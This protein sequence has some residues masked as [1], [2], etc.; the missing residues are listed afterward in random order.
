MQV[1]ETS[2]PAIGA[3]AYWTILVLL[4]ALGA[5]LRLWHLGSQIPFDDEWHAIDYVLDH[6]LWS[7]LGRYTRLGANSVPQNVYLRL[8]LRTVGLSEWSLVLPSLVAGLLFVWCYPRW[9]RARFGS[10]AGLL[11]AA[12]VALAPFLIF[13]SRFARPYGPLLLLEFLA[14]AKLGDWLRTGRQRAAIASVAFGVG[15]I[16]VHAT[17]LPPLL[18]AWL[19]AGLWQWRRQKPSEP[20]PQSVA[21]AALVLF[22]IAGSLT[23]F[24]QLRQAN[25]ARGADVPFT[26]RTWSALLQLLTGSS[27]IRVQVLVLGLVAAGLVVAARRAPRELGLFGGAALG[28]AAAVVSIHPLQAEVGAIF[29][30]YAMPMFLLPAMAIGV[31]VQHLTGGLVRQRLR[32]VVFGLLLVGLAA[33]FYF[34]GP[35]PDIDVGAASFTKQPVF[36]YDYG[37]F[38]RVCTKPNP[39]EEGQQ[40]L[41]RAQL[42]PF[43]AALAS[44]GG[45]APIVEYPFVY[46]QDYNRMYLAQALHGRPVL[47][48]YYDSGATWFDGFGLALDDRRQE[49][50]RERSR[51]YLL[52]DMTLDHVL[53]PPARRAGV[54]FATIVD[55]SDVAAM[56]ARGVEYVLLHWNLPL[57]FF[58]MLERSHHGPEALRFV[59]RI[60]AHLLA[61][62]GAPVV[63][64]PVLTVFRISR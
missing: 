32:Q 13:Y 56:R 25:P 17:A 49:R 24:W 36:Q 4:L 53:G 60:R 8:T 51:G 14:I 59:A 12:V 29:A 33:I 61:T 26:W 27:S 38:D 34:A 16:W 57:E 9:V 21:K 48:G 19:L 15:A 52:G 47:G 20:G 10:E 58:H 43:Y 40:V 54:A 7:L 31:A 2:R 35:L 3:R 55:I 44:M 42:H 6:D 5:Y 11:A 50:Q 46:G 64:D 1:S 39:V 62:L 22:A 45:S 28:S 41:C 23:A 63:D 30:R 18:V 37:E